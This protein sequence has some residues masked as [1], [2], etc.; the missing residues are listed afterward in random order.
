MPQQRGSRIRSRLRHVV[1]PFIETGL[2]IGLAVN[3]VLVTIRPPKAEQVLWWLGI[4]IG[5]GIACLLVMWARIW[6]DAG[7]RVTAERQQEDIE[8][9]HK[10]EIAQSEDRHAAQMAAIGLAR[11]AVIIRLDEQGLQ[12]AASQSTDAPSVVMAW[13]QRLSKHSAD[14]PVTIQNVGPQT[15]YKVSIAP[16]T[17]GDETASFG[18][19]YKLLLPNDRV[20]L[21]ALDMSGRVIS[22]KELFAGEHPWAVWERIKA[23]PEVVGDDEIERML[24]SESI[25]S[26]FVTYEDIQGNRYESAHTLFYGFGTARIVFDKRRLVKGCT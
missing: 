15:A 1:L 6:R 20:S 26:L 16:V 4:T 11:D 7:E 9:R 2:I 17:C 8:K 10:A 21:D 22:L 14:E 23:N 19:A 18:N 25:R 13:E 5:L 24:N 12:L 3:S